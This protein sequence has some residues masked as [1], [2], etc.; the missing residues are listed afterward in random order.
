MS[1]GHTGAVLFSNLTG[2]VLGTR[3]PAPALGSPAGPEPSCCRSPGV[4]LAR[5]PHPKT[6]PA[7]HNGDVERWAR[8]GA[9]V[10]RRYWASAARAWQRR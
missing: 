9:V 8:R 1:T 10:S 3:Q 2:Q 6:V 5:S 4:T 7:L